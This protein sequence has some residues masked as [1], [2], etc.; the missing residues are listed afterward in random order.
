MYHGSHSSESWYGQQAVYRVS[1]GNF[2]GTCAQQS[3][4][5]VTL[6]PVSSSV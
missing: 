3:L 4:L 1:L 6:L 2:V 5:L